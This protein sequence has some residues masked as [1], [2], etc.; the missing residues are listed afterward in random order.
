MGR[1]SWIRQMG[2]AV[3]IVLLLAAQG[4]AVELTGKAAY[5]MDPYSG[6]VFLEKDSEEPL[7]VASV[8]KLMTLVLIL[9]AV[10]RGEVS[11]ADVVTASSFAASK[12]GSRIWL[13]TGEQLPLGELVYAIAVGSANDAAVA[14]AEY[15]AGSEEKF[16]ELMN[17]RAKN[18]G[19]TATRFVNCTGLPEG[20]EHN[21]MSA[22]D[23]ARLARHAMDVPLLMDY[24][25]TYEYAMRE[26]TTKIP[27]LWNNNKLLRRYY[28]VDGMKTGFTSEAG[29]CIVATA[30]RENLRLIAVTLGHKSE[31]EREGAARTLLDYGFRKYESIQLYA[32]GEAVSSLECPTG[33]PRFVDVVLPQDFYVTVERGKELDL[34]TKVE[35]I[36]DPKPPISEGQIVGTLFASFGAEVVGTSP[37][38]VKERVEKLSLPALIYRMAQALAQAVF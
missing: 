29:Y 31:E 34:L 33:N 25:S 4:W 24:V 1:S 12:R 14:A 13:E 7:P 19:L 30:Q 15:L 5:L 2:T 35:L 3:L 20:D 9:E 10:D 8:S 37:L 36:Q 18:L 32:Q 23:V 6:R 26:D 17:A 27:V 11:L 21:L 28:G 38:T 22:K 16:V